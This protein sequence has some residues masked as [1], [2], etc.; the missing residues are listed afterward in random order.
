M[1]SHSSHYYHHPPP[2]ALDLTPLQLVLLVLVLVSL[3]LH[4]LGLSILAPRASAIALAELAAYKLTQLAESVGVA[5]LSG[6]D[7]ER[8]GEGMRGES[9]GEEDLKD[10]GKGKGKGKVV[11][12]YMETEEGKRSGGGQG[13][14]L[15]FEREVDDMT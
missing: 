11:R 9:S 12:T 8:V 1:A 6:V 2:P 5:G 14:S 13:G 4:S 15:D 10:K 7:W 3:F